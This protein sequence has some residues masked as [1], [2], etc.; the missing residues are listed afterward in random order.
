[1]SLA[2]DFGG[3]EN[4]TAGLGGEGE[5]FVGP[6]EEAEGEDGEGLGGCV[7]G[8]WFGEELVVLLGF[9][10][11]CVVFDSDVVFVCFLLFVDDVRDDC[12]GCFR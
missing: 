2:R 4:V 1:M 8:V 11:S 10:C 12:V 5:G 9:D 3:S 6:A 7:D